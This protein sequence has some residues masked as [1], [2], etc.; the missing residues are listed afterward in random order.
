MMAVGVVLS[1]SGSIC[2]SGSPETC[3]PVHADPA[4]LSDCPVGDQ[5]LLPH[6]YSVP[7]D[8]GGDDW[9]TQES[10]LPV[11]ATRIEDPGRCDAGNDTPC[12]RG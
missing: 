9:N 3:P 5:V 4:G 8:V 10:G 12:G 6:L 1:K 2:P 11:H 7:A